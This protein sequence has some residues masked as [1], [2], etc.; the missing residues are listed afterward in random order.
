MPSRDPR[1]KGP[2]SSPR[3]SPPPRGCPVGELLRFFGRPYVL[4]ILYAFSQQP[5]PL[6]FVELQRRLEV[7]PNTLSDRL[8]DL[9]R[10]GFLTREAYSEI[11][12]RVDYEATSKVRELI[13]IFGQMSEWAQ[14]NDL[15]HAPPARDI[16][17]ALSAPSAEQT[18]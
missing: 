16:E 3:T 6:R 14:R 13:P 11:P 12:P 7:S 9:V 10:A 5:G 2:S 18:A 15:R 8:H 17:P 4:D 1:P